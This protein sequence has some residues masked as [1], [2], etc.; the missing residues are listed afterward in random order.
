MRPARAAEE[1]EPEASELAVEAVRRR[2][3]EEDRTARNEY[4]KARELERE[5]AALRTLVKRLRA[6]TRGGG[7]ARAPAGQVVAQRRLPLGAA[8]Q[9]TAT[10]VPALALAGSSSPGALA[11]PPS[12][13]QGASAPAPSPTS[14]AMTSTH[15]ESAA[16]EA[17]ET[18]PEE[19]Q[20]AMRREGWAVGCPWAPPVVPR[21]S[22]VPALG[23]ESLLQ[24]LEE[25]EDEEQDGESDERSSESYEGSETERTF[26]PR[27]ARA[28]LS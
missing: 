26:D 28:T 1:L 27:L 17:S 13:M 24:M 12:A 14:A 4:V 18:L 6:E 2:W 16:S 9:A 21:P 22:F 11:P 5:N 15:S 19:G 8:A 23:L 25:E 7:G 20:E 3:L 10:T